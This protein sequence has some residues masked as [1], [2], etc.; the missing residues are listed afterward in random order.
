MIERDL[1]NHCARYRKAS[2]LPSFASAMRTT[3]WI[4]LSAAVPCCMLSSYVM[5]HEPT[6][7]LLYPPSAE[8][9][10]HLST[11]LRVP[12]AEGEAHA[13][14]THP[15][16]CISAHPAR[17][18]RPG[19][20]SDYEKREPENHAGSVPPISL[21]CF[22]WSRSMALYV[23]LDGFICIARWFHMYRSDTQPRTST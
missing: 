9:E 14:C 13:S 8:G 23:S 19:Y 17:R 15:V 4:V 22:I 20:C 18:W 2:G 10:A 21:N 3:R 16:R 7:R 6:P 5:C 12:S 11:R 1:G